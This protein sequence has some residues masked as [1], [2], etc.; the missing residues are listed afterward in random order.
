MP[1]GKPVITEFQGDN[2]QL[3]RSLKDTSRALDQ[4]A[5]DTETTSGRMA[6]AGD[7]IGDIG[8]SLLPLSAGLAAVAAG[9]VTAA[10][11]FDTSMRR[12]EGLVGLPADEV[13][14]LRDGVLSLAGSTTRAP[15]ELADALFTVTSAGFRGGDALDVL[16]R[17]ARASA[18]GLGDTRTIAE[19]VTGALN[20]YPAGMLS[21]AS[22][23]DILVATAR[24]GNF[25]ASQL[26]GA[27]GTIT[28]T[29]SAAGVGLDQVGGAVALLTRRNNDAN[30]S[31]TQINALIGAMIAPN[32]AAADALEANGSSADELRKVLAEQGL[33]AA[34]DLLTSATGGSAGAMK[35]ALGSDEA[36]RAALALTGATADEVSE[37]F[38]AVAGSVGITD[39]A[40]AASASGPGADM[41]QAMADV[42]T[43]GIALGD[44]LAPI[45]SAVA[46]G[47]STMASAFSGLPE[48]VQDVVAAVVAIGA[49]AGP[50]M[51]AVGKLATAASKVPAAMSAM[52]G[53]GSALMTMNPVLLGIGA[54]AATGAVIW[55]SYADAQ[56]DAEER[57]RGL[58]DALSSTEGALD[59]NIAGALMAQDTWGKSAKAF[60][61]AGLTMDDLIPALE[62]GSDSFERFQKLAAR[63]DGVDIMRG[64]LEKLDPAVRDVAEALLDSYDAGT[65]SKKGL[66]EAFDTLDEAADSFDDTRN[67]VKENT[68]AMIDNAQVA[69]D[70]D[71]A[72]ADML[73]SQVDAA[74]SM[75]ELEAA[76]KDATTAIEGETA[77][78]APATSETE[79]FE[80][81]LAEAAESAAD[82]ADEV[83]TASDAIDTLVGVNLDAE[84]ALLRVTDAIAELGKDALDSAGGLDINSEAGRNNREAMSDAAEAA[85][86]HAKALAE[87]GASAGE[88]QGALDAH[89]RQ[90]R[91]AGI[92]AGLSADDV[93]GYIEQLGLT[94]D[95]VDT[96]LALLGVESVEAGADRSKKAVEAAAIARESYIGVAMGS[97]LDA[98]L[99]VGAALDTAARDR[100]STITVRTNSVGTGFSTGLFRKDGGP[101]PGATH[102]PVPV[103]AHGGEY[104]L[105]ADVVDRIKSGRPSRGAGSSP[106]FTAAG[107][108][109]GA[110]TINL[111]VHAG[112]GADGPS[113]GRQIVD[114][115]RDYD[116]RNGGVPV[117]A[118]G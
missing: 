5:K 98:A 70:L 96:I 53:L 26:A 90:I 58:T 118:V 61:E 111:T 107:G 56:R 10:S 4:L 62:G 77:A 32:N 93:D 48:P 52:K 59:D 34:L 31:V 25:E 50:A 113:I 8:H 6:R 42:Q 68:L 51:I 79:D 88:I 91:D 29:A 63:K 16:D 1:G 73:R 74:T 84:G 117:R 57:A 75:E 67:A 94:P 38:G 115:L 44:A 20:A 19:A 23:T 103:M 89:I 41:R 108:G 112:M 100:L 30:Q 86:D 104:V 116:R 37:V 92:A 105:S 97:A 46:S 39:E 18:S 99:R 78:A 33:I 65:L 2:A 80:A 11:N 109:G 81:A 72:T 101:I 87:T 28:P 27:L 83:L 102:Q 17:A 64:E 45:A 36:L 13:A 21:A 24:A 22:A 49:V 110:T 66:K 55:K 95:N 82:V 40:F 47:V 15:Q 71:K 69:G 76:A 7:K 106:S 3:L 60:A 114:H 54:V 12:I 43:A 14:D 85:L 35:D 9:S